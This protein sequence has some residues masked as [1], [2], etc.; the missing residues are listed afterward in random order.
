MQIRL[1]KE[2]DY[3]PLMKLYNE[4]VGEDRYSKFDNDSFEKVIKNPQNFIF[5]SEEKGELVGF[6]SFSLRNVVRYPKKIAELDELFV[7]QHYRKK[8]IGEQLMQAVEK[9]AK[10]Q[11]C[12]RMFIE[13]HYDHKAAH[14]FYEALGYKNYGYHFIKNL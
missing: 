9:K 3:V 2:S 7:I 8:G 4:F 11:D 5:V 14:A 10:E 6:A 12:Y 1:A 13:S